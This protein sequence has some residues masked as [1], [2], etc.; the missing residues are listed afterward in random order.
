WIVDGVLMRTLN[1]NSTYDPVEGL[2]KFPSAHSRIQFS[3]WDGGMGAPGTAKWAGT[4]TDWSNQNQVYTMYVDWV[5]I[6]CM[7]PG[8]PTT[9]WPPPGYGP[10]NTTNSTSGSSSYTTLGVNPNSS[11]NGNNPN[12]SNSPDIIG[13]PSAPNYSSSSI[14]NLAIPIGSVVG[15][16]LGTVGIFSLWKC[17]FRPRHEAVTPQGKL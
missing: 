4:P 13:N 10:Q 12:D 7:T 16:V 1:R 17:V 11:Q 15:L 5:N 8:D 6:T 3:I 9:P 2:Y 14:K